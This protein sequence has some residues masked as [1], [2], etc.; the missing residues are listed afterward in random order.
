MAADHN[1]GIIE[2]FR[3]NQGRVGG[4]FEGQTL[5]L[6]HTVGR[7]TGRPRVNPAVYLLDGDRFV[8]FATKGGAPTNP[9]WYHNL[10]ANPDVE[11]EVGTETIPVRAVE[12]RDERE[13]E[14]LYARQVERVPGFADYPKRTNRR[15]PVIALERVGAA[16]S[17]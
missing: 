7:R 16:N 10:M 12:I 11:V 2:E 17:T 3:A 15:I 8:I 1:T 4:Y 9:H 6:L 13:R 14:E 5:L